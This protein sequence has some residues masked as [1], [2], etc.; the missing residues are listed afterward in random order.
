MAELR[1]RYA[2]PHRAFHDWSRIAAML[3]EAEE[4]AGAIAQRTA[5]VLAVLFHRAVFDRQLPGGP[6]RSAELMQ[7]MLHPHIPQPTLARAEALIMAI[8]RQEI[9]TT[10][11]ASLRGDAALLLDVEN[12]PLGAPPAVFDAQQAAYRREYAHLKDEAYAAGRAAA[13][14]TLLWRDRI[15]RTDRYYL[16]LE[17]R[18]RANI[19]RL[20][21]TLEGG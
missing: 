1:R 18:A 21:E 4:L 13:L 8:A 7:E 15:F 2:E 17:R 9:P 10:G 16:A 6:E 14:R 11:D 20:I 5:F 3:A 19:A 12:A